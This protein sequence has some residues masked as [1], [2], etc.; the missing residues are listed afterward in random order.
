M[1]FFSI[2]YLYPILSIFL[3]KTYNLSVEQTSIFFTVQIVSYFICFRIIILF[4]EKVFFCLYV[5]LGF[6]IGIYAQIFIGIH[7]LYR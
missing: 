6:I 4:Q 2:T 3:E 5:L 1:G 7:S